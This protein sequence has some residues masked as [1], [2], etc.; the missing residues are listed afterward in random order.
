VSAQRQRIVPRACVVAALVLLVVALLAPAARAAPAARVVPPATRTAAIRVVNRLELDFRGSGYP[1]AVVKLAVTLPADQPLVRD[2]LQG[3]GTS[4]YRRSTRWFL[5]ALGLYRS[6]E[7]DPAFAAPSLFD[8]VR[9][10]TPI[11]RHG[12]AHIWIGVREQLTTSGLTALGLWRIVVAHGRVEVKTVAGRGTGHR[13][14]PRSGFTILQEVHVDGGEVTRALPKPNRIKD[15]GARWVGFIDPQVVVREPLRSRALF[16]VAGG[17]RGNDLLRTLLLVLTTIWPAFVLL[18]VVG[19]DRWSWS[20]ADADIASDLRKQSGEVAAFAVFAGLLALVEDNGEWSWVSEATWA[21][22]G[23]VLLLACM[24]M[25]AAHGKDMASR[26]FAAIALFGVPLA[27]LVTRMWDG[28]VKPAGYTHLDRPAFGSAVALAGTLILALGVGVGLVDGAGRWLARRRVAVLGTWHTYVDRSPAVAIAAALAAA[29]VVAEQLIPAVQLSRA[30]ADQRSMALTAYDV[31]GVGFVARTMYLFTARLAWDLLAVAP[32]ALL[33]VGWRWLKLYGATSP[34]LTPPRGV[35]TLIVVAF[36]AFVGGTS[37]V[38]TY[39]LPLAMLVALAIVGGALALRGAQTRRFERLVAPELRRRREWLTFGLSVDAGDG[40]RPLN[41]AAM[42][43]AGPHATWWENGRHA[44]RLGLPIAILPAAH[45]LVATYYQSDPFAWGNLY[46]L[47][48]LLL[49]AA[50]ELAFW[51]VAAFTLGALFFALPGVSG[52]IKALTLAGAFAVS[53]LVVELLPGPFDNVSWLVLSLE[54]GLFF[55]VVGGLMDWATLRANG[56]PL[57][58]IESIIGIDR[59]R[60]VLTYLS[61]IAVAAF[62]I[63]QQVVSGNAQHAVT[64]LFDFASGQPPV[65]GPNR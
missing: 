63:L 44:A 23:G 57:T 39:A 32:F 41:A 37:S 33:V 50:S 24:T 38:M 59:T 17:K 7:D 15:D 9:W 27:V 8:R 5:S 47:I 36:A 12:R 6:T 56:L 34:G 30:V 53:Q 49:A 3:P 29:V 4:A 42:L 25:V 45:Y 55:V 46:G 14:R 62:F 19:R 61:P 20:P 54:A 40:G 65:A 28:F 43:G 26:R 18:W 48:D 10:G 58:A 21:A 64:S 60:L 16:L 11:I 52:F 31:D 13:I 22:A 2:M 35:R 1:S 51:S